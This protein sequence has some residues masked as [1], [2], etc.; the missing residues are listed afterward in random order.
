M[1]SPP[2]DLPLSGLRVLDFA[3]FLAGPA[4]ALRLADLGAEVIKIERPQGGDACRGLA[5]ND[6]MLEEDSL[7]F[8]TFN[9]NK[10][11]ITADLKSPEDLA[12]IKELIKTADVMIQNLRPGV[13]ERIGLG[14]DDVSEL[15]PKLVYGSVSGYGSTGPWANKPGQDLLA[16]ALSGMCYL[17]G[18]ASDGPVPTGFALLDITT[19]MNLVQGILAALLRRSVTGKGGLVEV[20]LLTSAIDLQFEQLTAFFNDNNRLPQRS[21]I[22]NAN[23]YGAAP[24]GVFETQQGYLA[25]AM[26]PLAR[27]AELLDAPEIAAFDQAQAFAQRDAIKSILATILTQKPVQEWLAILEPADIWCAEVLTWQQL[28]Q[29]DGF[30]ALEPLQTVTTANGKTA[31]TTRCP[32]RLDSQILTSP[33]GAPALGADTSEVLAALAPQPQPA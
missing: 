4:A 10:K 26:T 18:N 28:A 13:M 33:I 14:Y 23:V 11:S 32:I 22:A 24:Y 20:E 25:L 16:Q 30:K 19:G 3:Q 27:L 29:S 12:R 1:A 2:S 6:Q 31:V 21:Q 5:I 7:L 15:N 8:H 17:Q 9:R